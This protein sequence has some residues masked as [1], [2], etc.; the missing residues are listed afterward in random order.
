MEPELAR[1]RRARRLAMHRK[2][3]R[4]RELDRRLKT[5]YE[6]GKATPFSD[7]LC[8]LLEKLEIMPDE[9]GNQVPS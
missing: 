6:T 4:L 9:G 7:S 3:L 1:N 2:R 8:D 5:E